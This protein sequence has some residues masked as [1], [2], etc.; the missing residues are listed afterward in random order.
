MFQRVYTLKVRDQETGSQEATTKH[1][2]QHNMKHRVRRKSMTL[3]P[4]RKNI[5]EDWCGSDRFCCRPRSQQIQHSDL[6][7]NK[8]LLDSDV[9]VAVPMTTPLPEILAASTCLEIGSALFSGTL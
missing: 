4:T 6:S 7:K 5:K 9:E 8:Q 1:N 2:I 3:R